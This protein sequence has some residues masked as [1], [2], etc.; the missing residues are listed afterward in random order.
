MVSDYRTKQTVAT[1]YRGGVTV[2]V[3]WF[4]YRSTKQT[5]AADY[6]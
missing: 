4:F 2:H 5:V 6:R 1:N 3:S